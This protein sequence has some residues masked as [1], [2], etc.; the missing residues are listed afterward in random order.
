LIEARPLQTKIPNGG[1]VYVW[2]CRHSLPK[3]AKLVVVKIYQ[4]DIMAA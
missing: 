1:V 3:D 4:C 2:R